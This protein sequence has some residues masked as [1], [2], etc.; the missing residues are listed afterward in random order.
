MKQLLTGFFF[1]AVFFSAFA[2]NNNSYWQQEVDYKMT[3]DMDVKTFQYKGTQELK[4][5]NN[6]PDTLTKVFYH[7]YFNAFQP[8][9]EMDVRSRTIADPDGRVMDRISKL[10]PSE[11]GYIKPTLFT[12]NGVAADYTIKGTV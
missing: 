7:L 9:S 1:I 11:I 12:Q 2:Q 5:T 6:S 3:V 4:Y 10:S 8:G